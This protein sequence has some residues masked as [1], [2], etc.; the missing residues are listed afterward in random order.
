MKILVVDDDNQMRTLVK[1]ALFQ[2]GYSCDVT[3][4]GGEALEQLSKTTYDVVILDI[5]LPDIDGLEVLRRLS[6]QPPTLLP[7][8]IAM[9]GGGA[10][11]PGWFAGKLA[12][13]FGATQTLYKPFSIEDLRAAIES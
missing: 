6:E 13:A 2:M 1:T 4:S 5:L 9:S 7:R 12:E 10:K 11:L 8:V 3:G